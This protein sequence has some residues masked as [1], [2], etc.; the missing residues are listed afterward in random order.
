MRTSR[1]TLMTP[2]VQIMA[3]TK[4]RSRAVKSGVKSQVSTGAMFSM[5][6]CLCSTSQAAMMT[7]PIAPHGR[8]QPASALSGL[9]PMVSKM[10][11]A[12]PIRTPPPRAMSV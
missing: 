2:P 7:A 11:L 12:R 4:T 8:T 10:K 5:T 1:S 9:R 3:A 6:L